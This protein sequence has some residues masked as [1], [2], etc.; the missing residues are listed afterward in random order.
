VRVLLLVALNVLLIAV[1]PG[2]AQNAGEEAR[3]YRIEIGSDPGSVQ[4]GFIERDGRQRLYVTVKFKVFRNRDNAPANDVTDDI[5][6]EEDGRPVEELEITR[7]RAQKLTTVLALDVSGSM[8][9]LSAGVRKMDEAKVAARTFLDRLDARADTGLIL[10]DH[11]VPLSDPQRVCRPAE[12]PAKVAEN[13]R[14][15]AALI[16]GAQPRGGTAYLDA[17]YEGVHML[18]TID[19]RRAVLLMTDGMDT[20]SRQPRE[21]MTAAERLDWVIGRAKKARV[22]VYTIGIGE[23][24]KNEPVTSVLVLDHSGSMRGKASDT[25]RDRKI[26]ALQR[27]AARFIDLMRPNAQ[28]TLLP[29]SSTVETPEPFSSDRA[30]LKERIARLKPEGGTLLYDATYAGIETLAAS[31]RAGRKAVV[32]LT[33]GKDEAPGS[34]CSDQVVIDRARE[35]GVRLYMLGLGQ[36]RDINRAVM[37]RMATETGGKY[38]QANNQQQLFELFEKLSIDLHDEGIDEESLRKLADE[39]GGHYY[40]ARD[41]SK[42]REVFGELAEELQTTYT[43]TFPSRRSSHDGTARGIDISIWREGA[44]VSNV[45]S[46]DYNVHGV[47]VPEM[48]YRIYLILLALLGGLLLCPVGL[49]RL[50]RL[51]GGPA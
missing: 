25:D 38:Y 36:D 18:E 39:T 21:G 50:H 35:A 19:G 15:V 6:V 28:T 31:Q 26:D 12:N 10:F 48:D 22:P 20:N 11:E 47:I 5:R 1:G 27:A 33:D 42:L 46:A 44:R 4:S 9:A 3:D 37:E 2:A 41:V 45:G 13:R 43:V 51:Y 16:E 14:R 34:R 23:P 40:P 17:T 8:E 49:R 29:F 30:A 24:G 7:P 32:V